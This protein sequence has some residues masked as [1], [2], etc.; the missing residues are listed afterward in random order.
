MLAVVI[1]VLHIAFAVIAAGAAFYQWR[2]VHPTLA[3]MDESERRRIRSELLARWRGVIWTAMPVLLVTGLINFIAFKIPMYKEYSNK[4]VYHGLFLVK[5]L[6][7]LGVFHTATVLTL[8]GDKFEA[9]YRDKAGFWLGLMMVFLS[10]V[11]VVGAVMSNFDAVF[12]KPS[13]NPVL[14]VAGS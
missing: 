3:G 8:P 13:A 5:F 4:A 12:G 14:D 6:A 10:I 9:K 2:V 7:A 11:I 1:R